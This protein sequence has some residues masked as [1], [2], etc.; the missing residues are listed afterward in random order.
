MNTGVPFE[1]KVKQ[2]LDKGTPLFKVFCASVVTV[3]ICAFRATSKNERSSTF[4]R[5]P[6]TAAD[7]TAPKHRQSD[8][9]SDVMVD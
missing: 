3:K 9:V 7:G 8:S 4:V 5:A 1:K 2:F 6:L